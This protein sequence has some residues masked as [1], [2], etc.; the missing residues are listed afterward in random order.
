MLYTQLLYFA[1]LFDEQRVLTASESASKRSTF[2]LHHRLSALY[3]RLTEIE[4]ADILS[5][6]H[7]NLEILHQLNATVTRH[8]ERCG[9]RQV[10]LVKLFAS[11]GFV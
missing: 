4:T 10:D 8:L 3:A 5:N 11:M 9:R 1:S 7:V 2:F 6:L